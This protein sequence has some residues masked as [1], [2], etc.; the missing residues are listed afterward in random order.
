MVAAVQGQRNHTVCCLTKFR[1]FATTKKEKPSS[2]IS[3]NFWESFLATFKVGIYL[4]NMAE[5]FKEPVRGNLSGSV[6]ACGLPLPAG[7]SQCMNHIH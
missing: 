6:P 1:I 7:K 5:R 3:R 2:H 4:E